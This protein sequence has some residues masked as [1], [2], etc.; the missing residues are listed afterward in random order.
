MTGVAVGQRVN[1]PEYGFGVV[2]AAGLPIQEGVCIKQSLTVDFDQVGL[3]E[4][5]DVQP[6]PGYD[7]RLGLP[8]SPLD[9]GPE[10][11]ELEKLTA[12]MRILDRGQ[13]DSLPPVHPL[14]GGTLDR[15]T[16][17][18]LAGY[19]GTGKTFIALDW[20]LSAI[21]FRPW[22]ARHVFGRDG[23]PIIG[24]TDQ[25]PYRALY[26]AAEGAYGLSRRVAA[27]E[28]GWGRKAEHLQ[29][30]P[31]A[32]NLLSKA[33]VD[34]VVRYV[35]LSEVDVVVIDT[36]SRCMPGA[37]ENSAKDMS[38]AVVA[39]DRIKDATNGGMV[40]AVHHTGKDKTTVRGSSVLEGA[41]DTVYQV[42]GD[43]SYMKLTRT[44]RKDGPLFDQVSL[45]LSDTLDSCVL[46]DVRGQ[47]QVPSWDRLFRVFADNFADTGASKAELRAVADMPPASFARAL[48][49]LVNAGQLVNVGT[50]QRAF[51]KLG[52]VSDD[53][54]RDLVRSCPRLRPDMSVRP[55][56]YRQGERTDRGGGRDAEASSEPLETPHG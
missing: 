7:P 40:L 50:D 6:I 8:P 35:Q 10:P 18:L 19:W 24:A 34:K 25:Q 46:E 48:N 27:W 51:Y 52:K 2:V 15:R 56:A 20:T 26:V 13:L 37:D 33:D 47:S 21:T 28:Y 16:L 32:L 17:T 4:R 39:L 23:E 53:D 38:S 31:Q 54:V 5:I 44:K 12:M 22:Q 49:A 41:C 43:A 1:D 29:V 11:A 36:L 55:P 42:E 45:R 9:S 14:I 30:M 3:K